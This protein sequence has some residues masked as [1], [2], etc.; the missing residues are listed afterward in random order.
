MLPIR[1]IFRSADR[2]RTMTLSWGPGPDG[3][4]RAYWLAGAQP[5]GRNPDDNG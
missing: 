3:K 5:D 1:A 2:P 4:L